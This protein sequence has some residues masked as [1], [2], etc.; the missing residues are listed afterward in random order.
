MAVAMGRSHA[1]CFPSLTGSATGQ[2]LL[3]GEV[4]R[5]GDAER[6]AD[7]R[8]VGFF[9]VPG[10]GFAG[11]S[12]FMEFRGRPALTE[13]SDA[14]KDSDVGRRRWEVSEALTGVHFPLSATASD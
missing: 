6:I 7:L 4:Y 9:F 5:A 3:H 10:N 11:P 13:R 14:A 1:V 2:V 8:P 12:G